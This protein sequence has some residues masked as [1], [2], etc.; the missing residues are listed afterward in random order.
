MVIKRAVTGFL[1]VAALS[2]TYF[3]LPALYLSLFFT[4]IATI[5]LCTEWPLLMRPHQAIFWLITPLYP[6]APFISLMLLNHDPLYRGLI[7]Y[8]FAIVFSFDTGS[9]IAG[10]TMGTTKICPSISP[11]KTWQGS[12]GG[13]LCTLVM[14]FGWYHYHSAEKSWVLLSLIT[15]I[16]CG[17]ALCGDL[18]ESWLKRRARIK[19]SGSFLP[20]HGGFLDRFDSILFVAP[21][22]WITKSFLGSLFL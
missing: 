11:G 1:L 15:A 10:K 21:I 19:D 7:F 14:L 20:G 2:F 12:I 6:V 5:I 16:I 8:L 4:I 18:F 3:C 9:Y 13:Y 17:I 22:F